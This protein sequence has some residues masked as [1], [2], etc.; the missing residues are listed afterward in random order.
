[1]MDTSLQR[2]DFAVLKKWSLYLLIASVSI[3]ALAGIAAILAGDFGMVQI[4]IL[5]TS[6]VIAAASLCSI[7]CGT[8]LEA[9]RHPLL[10]V[11]GLV[12]TAVSAAMIIGG[13][14]SEVGSGDYWKV[15]VTFA[16]FGVSCSHVALLSL[17]R[18]GGAFRWIVPAAAVAVFSVAGIFSAALWG[19]FSIEP[20]LRGLGVAAVL[21]GALTI[22]V[23][24]AHRLS[25][26]VDSV[27]ANQ[28]VSTLV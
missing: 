11:C 19:E 18:P 15:S 23:P 3:S 4:K 2:F 13:I 27:P 8:A 9:R 17:A 22:L 20:L 26:S 21:D 5:L 12:L 10:P 24:V 6:G 16:T 1:M 25:R 7:C 14:W 28:D